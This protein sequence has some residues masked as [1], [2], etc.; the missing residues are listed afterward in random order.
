M[1]APG[2]TGFGSGDHLA[3]PRIAN[4]RTRELLRLLRRMRFVQDNRDHAC[5]Y[6]QWLRISTRVSHGDKEINALLMGKIAIDDLKMNS[7]QEFRAALR[8]NIPRRYLDPDAP[9]DGQPLD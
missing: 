9:W 5:F 4:V 7:V 2:R 6:H 1:G 8:G 3:M